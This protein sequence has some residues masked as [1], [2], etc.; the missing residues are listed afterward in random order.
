MFIGHFATGLV[1]KK[2][3]PTLPL[4]GMFIAVQFLDLLWPILVLLGIETVA[5][6]PGITQL[7][8]LDFTF[9]PYTHSLLMAA[10]WGVVFGL[11]YFA[12]TKNRQHALILGALVLS[13]WFLDLLV[14]RPDLLLSPF[15]DLKVGLGLWN[16]PLAEI[17]IEFSL[18]FTGAWV[19][20]S[21]RKPS[22]KIAYWSLIGILLVIQLANFF[23]PPPPNIPSIAWGGNLIWIF[24]L[25][26]WWIEKKKTKEHS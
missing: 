9:Y 16:H 21:T 4:A 8:P 12:F 20:Y 19:Y 10:V 3:D 1:T 13:H 22:K 14:H 25:W 11:I 24:I 17:T 18:F 2:L 6:K 23:G 15:G 26:A 5:I 7:T